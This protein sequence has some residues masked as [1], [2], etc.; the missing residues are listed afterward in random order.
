MDIRHFFKGKN[1]PA[2]TPVFLNTPPKDNGGVAS[3]QCHGGDSSQ[4][5]RRRQLQNFRKFPVLAGRES[6][7]VPIFADVDFFYQCARRSRLPCAKNGSPRM[8]SYLCPTVLSARFS[9]QK[10][11]ETPFFKTCGEGQL[12]IIPSTCNCFQPR[13]FGSSRRLNRGKKPGA[14]AGPI[15]LGGGS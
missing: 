12:V 8:S 3:F 6:A 14:R 15:T 4:K 2:A 5:L 13:E 11:T 1:P 10:V 9:V 7:L